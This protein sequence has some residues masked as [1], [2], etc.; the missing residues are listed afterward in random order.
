[1][2]V[3]G[4][5]GDKPHG[6]RIFVQ[7]FVDLARPFEQ[8]QEPFLGDGSWLAPL[9]SA[10]EEDGESL[11]VRIGPSW[12]AG[13]VTREVRVVLQPA[14]DR[15]DALIIPLSWEPVG[16]QSLIPSLRGDLGIAPLGPDN[17]RI[18]LSASYVPPL[19]ELGVRLDHAAMRRV[20]ASTV[21]SFLA[22][23]AASLQD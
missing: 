23:V 4:N 3:A 5:R 20:A 22:R 21:R 1:M 6:K 14:W 12:G 7:D 18:T 16:L 17:C 10:A 9:A 13:R 15:G 11:R 8:V 2:V 19:G